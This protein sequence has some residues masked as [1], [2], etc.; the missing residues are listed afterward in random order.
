MASTSFKFWGPLWVGLSRG[1]KKCGLIDDRDN[2][3]QTSCYAALQNLIVASAV[4]AAARVRIVVVAVAD[5]FGIQ[6]EFAQC[7]RIN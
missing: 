1:P 6:L 3:S 7:E 2:K 4:A 5:D